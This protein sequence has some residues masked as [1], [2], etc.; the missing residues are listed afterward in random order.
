[1]TDLIPVFSWNIAAAL[2]QLKTKNQ[3]LKT[4]TTTRRRT[5]SSANRDFGRH[6]E[7]GTHPV[8]DIIDRDVFCFLVKFLV[9]QHGKTVY[10]VHVVSF[11][12]FIQ[13][14]RQGRA[15]SAAGL[16]KYPNR[17]DLIVL[18]IILQYIFGFFRQVNH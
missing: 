4:S 3:K 1:L 18:E 14:H 11:S 12:R 15:S 6:P 7:A 5:A 2:L 16:K 10:F 8:G 17:A 13:N 9:D